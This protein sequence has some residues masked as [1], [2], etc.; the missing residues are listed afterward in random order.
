M[1]ILRFHG[2]TTSDPAIDDWIAARPPALAPLARGCF[3]ALRGAGPGIQELLHDGWPTVCIGDAA[4]ACVQVYSAHVN[5]SFFQGAALPD[6]QHLLAG[7]GK[8]MRHVKLRPDV[9]LP[10][11]PLQALI[12]ASYFDLA[13]RLALD[14][15]L[16]QGT[17]FPA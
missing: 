12:T 17:S 8:F 10:A 3:D 14:V 5:L 2:A 1:R 7:A 11:G 15:A 4:L 13:E 16:P 9:G 6:P